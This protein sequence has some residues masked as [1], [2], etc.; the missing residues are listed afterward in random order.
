MEKEEA[1]LIVKEFLC[2]SDKL[3]YT[4]TEQEKTPLRK[5]FDMSYRALCVQTDEISFT[6]KEVNKIM[7][8]IISSCVD[9]TNGMQDRLLNLLERHVN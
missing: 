3:N 1:K 5:A 6:E 7:N 2:D 4:K 9:T 8:A